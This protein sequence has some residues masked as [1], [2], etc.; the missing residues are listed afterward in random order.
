MIRVYYFYDNGTWDVGKLNNVL[1]EEVVAEILKIPINPS[2]IDMAYWAPTSSGQFTTK[3]AWEI[4]RQ[5][6]LVN[7]V[8]N[9]IRHKSIP[10]T[11]SFFLL[12]LLQDW[13]PVNLRLK[14]K[15]FRLASKCQHCNS[16]ESLLHVMWECLVAT[17][18]EQNYA[19]HRNLGMY[20]NRVVWRV[21]KLI[22]QLFQE[23]QFHRWQWRG[24]LQNAQA[25]GLIFQQASPHPPKIFSWHKPLAGEFKLNVDGSSKDNFQNAAGGGLLWD[26][27]GTMIFLFVEN[28][29]P[30]N[31]LQ[32]ELMAL[33]RGLLLCIEYNVTR[34]WIEMDVKVVVQMI[35]EGHQGSSK[36]QYLLAFI[37]RCL[38][39]MSFRISHIHRE[40]N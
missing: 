36:T 27:T 24:D 23:R 38:S 25:W 29:G 31:S 40:G 22:Q 5:Q 17:Q 28:C 3:S 14:T 9:L 34:L 6:Q 26:H 7:P 19:K 10:L 13:I 20:F 35:H 16:E 30:Y 21:L 33:H 15:G 18:V 2:N 11:I 12:R 32:A 8:F 4:I 39:G 1:P 37:H